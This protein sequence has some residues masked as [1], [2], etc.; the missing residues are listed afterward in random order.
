MNMHGVGLSISWSFLDALFRHCRLACS[1]AVNFVACLTFLLPPLRTHINMTKS[2]HH[3]PCSQVKRVPESERDHAKEALKLE[4]AAKFKK[5]SA[6]V[7]NHE[8]VI[9]LCWHGER[10]HPL[11]DSCPGHP[12]DSCKTR[13]SL[14]HMMV[15]AVWGSVQFRGRTDYQAKEGKC[16]R[17]G[18]HAADLKSAR[19]EPRVLHGEDDSNRS[20]SR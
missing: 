12:H 19:S 13:L 5:L 3:P 6:E 10:C 17:R 4:K 15:C 20:L 2:T 9:S 7:Q 8:S 11:Q 16:L 1:I 18:E 14:T